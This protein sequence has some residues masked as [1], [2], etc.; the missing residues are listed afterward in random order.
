MQA[1]RS[2][3]FDRGVVAYCSRYQWNGTTLANG[4]GVA[5]D[6]GGTL[7]N[8]LV[9]RC[10]SNNAGGVTAAG[11]S[12][13]RNCTVV[14]NSCSTKLDSSAASQHPHQAEAKDTVSVL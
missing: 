6:N 11:G 13:V 5:L 10:T 14:S 9:V 7:R 4:G 1:F 12:I 8:S 2:S 3:V